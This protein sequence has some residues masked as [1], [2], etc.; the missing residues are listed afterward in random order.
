M[1]EAN[2][3]DSKHAVADTPPTLPIDILYALPNYVTDSEYAEWIFNLPGSI[4]DL[5]GS[6]GW[7]RATQ[8]MRPR[9]WAPSWTDDQ[10]MSFAASPFGRNKYEFPR[11]DPR[12]L[13]AMPERY[14]I[15]HFVGN[16][17]MNEDGPSLDT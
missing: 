13:R 11:I 6:V 14:E 8:V 10:L 5:M 16:I 2:F 9:I 12:E 1:Y 4:N 17:L 3:L 7:E 15:V